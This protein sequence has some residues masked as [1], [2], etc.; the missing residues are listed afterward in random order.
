MA[1]RIPVKAARTPVQA[2]TEFR[3]EKGAERLI[4]RNGEVNASS[5]ADLWRQN[6]K[7]LQAAS[8]GQIVQ[9]GTLAAAQDFKARNRELLTAAFND[10]RSYRVLGEKMA[11]A[12]YITANRQ[13]F[14]RKFLT[15][16]TVDQGS[17]P[18]FK[19]ASKN[20]TAVYSTS[21]TQIDA[22]IA[23]DRWFTPPEFQIVARPFVPENE[24]NQSNNDVLEEKFVEAQESLMVAEDR[25]LYMASNA[26]V[27]LDN[28]LSVISSQLTPYT[29]AR[30]LTKVNRWG[31]KTPYVL[32]ASDLLQD[33]IGNT[34]MQNAIDPV[35]RHELLLT[36]EL[37]VLWGATLVTDAYR[38]PEHKVLN[39]G[40]FF[41]FADPLNL[42]AYSDRGGLQSAPVGIEV[43][44]V[45][46]R[47]WVV[48]ESFAMTLANPRAVAKGIRA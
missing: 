2:A 4:G 48:W 44:K 33:I 7:L 37:G 27:N 43:E 29:F 12:L 5:K 1:K 38:H 14:L 25:L 45:P 31:L 11:E 13:G 39:Q 30:V 36:G 35:A 16:N 3:T 47:G 20:V 42:G 21:P 28:E 40:E 34:E 15:K 10:S 46:G 18:R 26:V 23:L 8:Q 24:I 9:D 6:A 32:M 22:Q 17:I 19:M 41:V